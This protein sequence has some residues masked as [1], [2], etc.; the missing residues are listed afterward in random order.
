MGVSC[1][2]PEA[3]P[4]ELYRLGRV[5]LHRMREAFSNFVDCVECAE[6][7]GG[8]PRPAAPPRSQP[9]FESG[10]RPLPDGDDLNLLVDRRFR[11]LGIEQL[12]FAQTNRLNALW[13]D[14]EGRHQHVA[15]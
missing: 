7:P 11:M 12:F 1:R 13:R 10:S 6:R 2:A 8:R 4:G 9:R 3:T 14:F 5:C 15:E